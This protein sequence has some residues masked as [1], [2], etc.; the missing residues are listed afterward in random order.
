VLSQTGVT[1]APGSNGS[2]ASR[3]I[4]TRI[5]VENDASGDD[6]TVAV[7]PGATAS[8]G[9]SDLAELAELSV[10]PRLATEPFAFGPSPASNRPSSLTYDGPTQSLVHAQERGA[11]PGARSVHNTSSGNG[12]AV[13]TDGKV[14][15]LDDAPT[16]WRPE[17]ASLSRAA[18]SAAGTLAPRSP[19]AQRPSISDNGGSLAARLDHPNAPVPNVPGV[20]PRD[21]ESHTFVSAQSEP[22]AMPGRGAAGVS[23]A[24]GSYGRFL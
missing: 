12:G 20:I 2:S 3:E 10:S 19:T 17:M 14:S 6:V 18:L 4:E 1:G 5:V 23:P 16:P 7:V 15:A 13:S 24:I 8:T 11:A 22:L 21:A 9:R